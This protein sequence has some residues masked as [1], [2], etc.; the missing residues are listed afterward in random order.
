MPAKNGRDGAGGEGKSVVWAAAREMVTG[1]GSDGGRSDTP[2][3]E[4]TGKQ[5]G[6][7][8]KPT[9]SEKE[10]NRKLIGS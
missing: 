5:L 6:S 9:G 4:A 7:N 2:D 1:A 3:L 10:A 8:R